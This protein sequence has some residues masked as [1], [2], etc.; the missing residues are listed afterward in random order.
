MGLSTNV[1]ILTSINIQLFYALHT[2]KAEEKKKALSTCEIVFSE[3]W[4]STNMETWMFFLF[5]HKK[6]V[7]VG[8]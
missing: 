5:L 6:G 7:C 4:F 3:Y 8:S 1:L 2:Y